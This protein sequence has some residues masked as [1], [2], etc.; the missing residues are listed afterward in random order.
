[1]NYLFNPIEQL[2]LT[3]DNPAEFQHKV[4]GWD[5]DHVQLVPGNYCIN[6]DLVHTQNIQ[7][8]NVTHYIGVHERGCIP[9]RACAIS[10]PT[11][12]GKDPL[13]YCGTILQGDECPVLISGEEFETFSSGGINYFTIVVDTDLLNREAVLLTGHP[14]TA[15]IQSQ[16]VIIKKQDRLRLVQKISMMM[17]EL[18][19]YPQHLSTVQQELLEK[20]IVEQLL[21]SIHTPSGKKLKIPNRRQVAWKAEQLMRQNPQQQLDIKQICNRIGCS[22]RTLHLGFKERSGMTP[23]QYGRI[24]ALNGVRRQLI[25]LQPGENISEIA[26]AWGFYHLGRFSEQYKQLFTELPSVTIKQAG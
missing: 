24:L 6:V 15:Q 13:Y 22:A 19:F 14:F 23:G 10:L 1:M 26:M 3:C 8:S 11:L 17:H 18:K 9:P 25:H 20:Q 2:D 12:L 5:I 21:L 4:I 7:L 16:R